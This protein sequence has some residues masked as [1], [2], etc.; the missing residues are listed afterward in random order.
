MVFIADKPADATLLWEKNIVPWL[1]S[2]ADKF[3]Q[4]TIDLVLPGA[5]IYLI[6]MKLFWEHFT[7]VVKLDST[8]FLS[9]QIE[10]HMSPN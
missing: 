4:T 1:I 10:I 7:S 9:L 5:V 8:I 2:R 6:L 3:K